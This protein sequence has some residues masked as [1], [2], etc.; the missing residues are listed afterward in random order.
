MYDLNE[1]LKII[2]LP[3]GYVS[4]L[5][6]DDYQSDDETRNLKPIS[7]FDDD[8]IAMPK[9][10]SLEFES[11]QAEAVAN[12]S[13]LQFEIMERCVQDTS[14][15]EEGTA[16]ES[17]LETKASVKQSE[18]VAP[19]KTVKYKWQKRH[20]HHLILHSLKNSLNH[21]KSFQVHVII[22]SNLLVMSALK[23]L[24]YRLT[25][26]HYRKMERKSALPKMK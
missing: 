20:S 21:Q 18:L 22:S 10:G 5:D 26:M 11:Q 14:L 16:L 1:A 24:L 13:E 15:C 23:L 2:L 7:D 4:D 3:D 12:E 8:E 9:M 6:D 17:T 19:K 25:F